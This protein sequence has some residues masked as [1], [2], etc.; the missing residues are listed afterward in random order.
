LVAERWPTAE[1]VRAGA[2]KLAEQRWRRERRGTRSKRV[3][4]VARALARRG[5]DEET[6]EDVVGDWEEQEEEG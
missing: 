1:K 2:A 6:I 4:R 5:F 3:Q